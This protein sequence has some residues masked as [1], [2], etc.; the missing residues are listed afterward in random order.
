[1]NLLD[2]LLGSGGGSV[3]GALGKNANLGETDIKNVLRRLV[4]AL[5]KG[6]KN[7]I[8]KEQGLDGLLNALNSGNH[9]RFL[10]ADE[11]NQPTTADEGNAILG[12]IFGSKDVSRNVAA[13]AARESGVRPGVVK[14]LLPLV[15]SAAMAS[16]SKQ[17][18][19]AG[20][21]GADS[22]AEQETGIDAL[23]MINGLL[24]AD[25]DGSITDDLL[26]LAKK[27]F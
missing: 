24:D 10:D 18:S 26:N 15:A 27:F 6:I 13:H 21:L 14:Q 2:T 9:Q 17:S 3:L 4:P 16:L 8:S 11:M 7:N 19:V 1:M 20:L 12:H 23:G 25:D 22:E 5:S